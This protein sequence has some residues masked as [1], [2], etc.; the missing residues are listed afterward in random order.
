MTSSPL[1]SRTDVDQAQFGG[2][3]G[4]VRFCL[5][6]AVL[7]GGGGGCSPSSFALYIWG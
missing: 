1:V 2:G 3:G 5:I 4:G 7:V 6:R